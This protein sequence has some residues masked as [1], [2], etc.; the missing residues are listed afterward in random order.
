MP[1]E[2]NIPIWLILA[3]GSLTLYFLNQHFQNQRKPKQ[4]VINRPPV[5]NFVA[6]PKM[7]LFMGFRHKNVQQQERYQS[8]LPYN[9]E[10][11]FAYL[12]DSQLDVARLPQTDIIDIINKKY[13]NNTVLD[14]HTGEENI[15]LFEIVPSIEKNVIAIGEGKGLPFATGLL[16]APDLV[17]TAR[18]AL[19]GERISRLSIKTNFQLTDWGLDGHDVYFIKDVV[20]DN[21]ALDYVI[22]RLNQRVKDFKPI[23]LGLVDDHEG[24]SIL[25][26]HPQGE[27]KKISVDE[28]L[29]SR[30]FSYNLS[31][32][33]QSYK[34]SSGGVYVNAQQQIFALHTLHDDHTIT[35][36]WMK[37]IYNSSALLRHL[38]NT[39][40]NYAPKP[41][42]ESL[43]KI[44][45]YVTPIAR[46]PV[47]SAWL[48]RIRRHPGYDGLP[49]LNNQPGLD[50]TYHH[51]IP[52][53]DMAFLWLLGEQMPGI[54]ALL[55]KMV[56][57]D[58]DYSVNAVAY[59][60]WDLFIG[61]DCNQ[62][63]DDPQADDQREKFKPAS[64]NAAHWACV[65]KLYTAIN[66]CWETHSALAACINAPEEHLS[67]RA[68]VAYIEANYQQ[69]IDPQV[70]HIYTDKKEIQ[71]GMS[72]T[73]KKDID[74]VFANH[75]Q[76]LQQV[77]QCLQSISKLNNLLHIHPYVEADW[78][79][80]DDEYFI[81]GATILPLKRK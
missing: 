21:P 32:Y 52:I 6:S 49:T 11:D 35:A 78:G 15:P 40:G 13:L 80:Q 67:R 18:H 19:E 10:E 76:A 47:L 41:H 2:S 12:Y 70:D 81:K 54:K 56:N 48:E 36:T 69:V 23:N 73:R 3:L 44:S 55:Q 8:Y 60:P 64:F 7:D 57:R 5:R 22:V 17:I 66:H 39:Q 34:G 16:I 33:H 14:I 29:S 42:R 26:H 27:T 79:M 58:I 53:N 75:K 63:C 31:A 74:K 68:V 72:Q 45:S 51:I 1:K 38:Y 61:P 71:Q 4:R 9:E 20:D 25:I 37:D 62:R 46:D 24:S 28:T 30:H 59:A 43:F 77:Y 65:Q 50:Y